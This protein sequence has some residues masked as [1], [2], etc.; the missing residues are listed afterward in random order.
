MDLEAATQTVGFMLMLVNSFLG[1]LPKRLEDLNAAFNAKDTEAMHRIAHPQKGS[2]GNIG[3]LCLS[4]VPHE[5]D[6]L[7]RQGI[8]EGFEDKYQ[9]LRREIV[10][11]QQAL[12]QLKLDL[13]V[14]PA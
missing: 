13:S 5:F 11:A 12:E 4:N 1:S 9:E 7:L 3:A 2:A 10:R 8:S 14:K 6:L